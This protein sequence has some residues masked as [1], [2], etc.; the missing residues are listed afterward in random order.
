ME[1]NSTTGKRGGILVP[2]DA[3]GTGTEQQPVVI[4]VDRR[5]V[6]FGGG[7]HTVDHPFKWSNVMAA[8]KA[9]HGTFSVRWFRTL[10]YHLL[11]TG[12]FL[13]LATDRGRVYWMAQNEHE[14]RTADWKLHF[15]IAPEDKWEEDIGL[16]WD[17]VAA[18]FM[19]R[20]CDAGMKARYTPWTDAG[21]R[22]RELTVYIFEFKAAYGPGGPMAELSPT[23]IEHLHYLGPEFEYFNMLP[24][25]WFDFIVDAEARL[26]AAGLQS[27]GVADGDLALPGCQFASLRNEA[28]V[29]APNPDWAEGCMLPKHLW[30]YPPNADGYNGACDRN[31]LENT[32]TLLEVYHEAHQHA[33]VGPHQPGTPTPLT[34]AGPC[35]EASL[36]NCM[37]A[38]VWDLCAF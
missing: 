26:K 2:H 4:A 22:G 23:G 15:S 18:L 27:N 8:P 7:L 38:D 29:R 14:H 17:I 32:I 33:M 31:P 13:R 3:K 36:R 30:V 1:R 37:S 35:G 5:E 24:R 19:E 25:F 21:Q 28:Y 12:G 34:R 10:T 9:D 20:C 16:A 6:T 11:H